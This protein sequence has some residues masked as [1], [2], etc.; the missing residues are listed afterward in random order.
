MIRE[1]VKIK[2]NFGSVKK[3]NKPKNPNQNQK[4]QTKPH[5]LLPLI[6]YKRWGHNIPNYQ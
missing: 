2:Y 6:K 1:T 4:N 5:K 3:Q